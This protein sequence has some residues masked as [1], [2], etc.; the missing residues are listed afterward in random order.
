EFASL[1]A[2]QSCTYFINFTPSPLG[3][4]SARTATLTIS[5]N[6]IPSGT[7]T[8]TLQ[9][10]AN[11]GSVFTETTNLTFPQTNVGSSVTQG[12]LFS[13]TTNAAVVFNGVTYTPTVNPTYSS[14][15][16]ANACATGK[17]VG[18]FTGTCVIYIKFS[19]TGVSN[20]GT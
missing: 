2:G 18:A 5:D 13:N 4:G 17:S 20:P 15:S 14:D 12:V 19:P 10:T 7:Q 3:S 11:S 1:N 9:G 6:A 8:V 16:G